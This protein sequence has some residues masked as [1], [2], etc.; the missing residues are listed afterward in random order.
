M[1]SSL[2]CGQLEALLPWYVND[3]APS[4]DRA[5]VEDHLRVCGA[6]RERLRSELELLAQIRRPESARMPDA[7]ESWQRFERTLGDVA[8]VR[9]PVAGQTRLLRWVVAGQ[10]AALAV[11]A[12]LLA[13]VLW[14]QER[15]VPSFR[16]VTTPAAGP[17][18]TQF[19]VRVAA[20]AGVTAQA[21]EQIARA[22]GARVVNGPSTQGVYT[23]ELDPAA[24]QQQVLAQLR[25]VPELQFVEQVGGR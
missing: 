10:A 9:E 25:T 7:I 15:S 12:V 19:T 20:A 16:T 24:V 18:A 23:L 4:A 22:H 3:T 5:L 13:Q 11:L 6:C 2:Q 17:A 1:T 14:R 8:P 21:V